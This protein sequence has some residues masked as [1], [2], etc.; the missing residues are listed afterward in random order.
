LKITKL[1]QH[2]AMSS[3]FADLLTNNLTHSSHDTDSDTDDFSSLPFPQPLSRPKFSS[4]DFNTESFLLSHSQ[5]RTLDDL[6]SELR[7]WV[8]KLEN[9]ME[10]LIEEDWQG[11]L[12]LGRGLIGGESVV[13]DA[14]RRTRAVDREVQVTLDSLGFADVGC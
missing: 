13:K 4:P 11:Y 6:R 7:T 5:F 12:S 10:T 3:I 1:N 8:D 2:V 9:E 14:E